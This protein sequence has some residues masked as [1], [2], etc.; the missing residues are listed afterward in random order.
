MLSKQQKKP[1]VITFCG[2]NGVG[3]STNLAKV[4]NVLGVSC[5]RVVYQ[6]V[7]AYHSAIQK[8][9]NVTSLSWI[10]SGS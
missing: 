3:K 5:T 7:L 8:D 2:V 9:Y 4:L 10:P 1:Y 6:H